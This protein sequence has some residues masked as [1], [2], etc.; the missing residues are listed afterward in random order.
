MVALAISLSTRFPKRQPTLVL[1]LRLKDADISMCIE[2]A[3]YP[4]KKVQP[5]RMDIDQNFVLA[6]FRH[7]HIGGAVFSADI[8]APFPLYSHLDFAR[9]SVLFD[10][11]SLH[12]TGVPGVVT[13]CYLTRRDG[14][15]FACTMRDDDTRLSS[16]PI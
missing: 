11:E 7:H 16:Q 15:I 6:R 14:Q 12:A 1:P 8:H 13:S 3:R 4:L 5:G 2:Q 9:M 10:L